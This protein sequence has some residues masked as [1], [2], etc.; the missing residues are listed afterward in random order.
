M[1]ISILQSEVCVT[2]NLV[3]FRRTRGVGV[4]YVINVDKMHLKAD[5]SGRAV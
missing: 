3:L 4:N 5:D 1:L 2:Y